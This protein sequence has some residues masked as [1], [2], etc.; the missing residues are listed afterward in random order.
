MVRGGEDRGWKCD[1][2][3]F[4]FLTLSRPGHL[5]VLVNG[6]LRG[7]ELEPN[8]P[9][10]VPRLSALAFGHLCEIVLRRAWVVDLLSRDVVDGG[11]GGDF[12]DVGRVARLV[13]A[14]VGARR[15]LHSLLGVGVLGHAR[16]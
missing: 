5:L 9:R 3:L 16:G 14:D 2:S 7:V 4:L 8:S 11:S 13:A 1:F 15:V 12:G 6:W 10:S